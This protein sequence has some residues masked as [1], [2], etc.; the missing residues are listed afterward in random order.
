MWSQFS[1]V[2]AT[3]PNGWTGEAVSPER[4]ITQAPDNRPICFPYMKRMVSLVM[5]DLG[6]VIVMTTASQACAMTGG[7]ATPVYF[8]G[9][10]F[11]KDRQRFM[12]DKADFT[13][14][15]A[16][17]ANAKKRTARRNQHC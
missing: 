15:P 5:A 12:V 3:H 16:L 17:A 10:A 14:S 8:L 6:A 13:R 2:A 4:I 1:S 11:A 7:A 9:G